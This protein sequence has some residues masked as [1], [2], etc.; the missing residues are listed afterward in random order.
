MNA[1]ILIDDRKIRAKAFAEAEKVLKKI[2]RLEQDLASFHEKDQKLFDLWSEV[3][4]REDRQEIEQKHQEYLEL[5]RFNNWILAVAQQLGISEPEA[6]LLLR[7]EQKK[8]AKGNA[9]V[10]RRIDEERLAR[11]KF[12]AD[13][14]AKEER[15]RFER[16]Q[17][18]STRRDGP[19][20]DRQESLFD[21]DFFAPSL[22][23]ILREMSDQQIPRFFGGPRITN[24][25]L[26][27]LFETMASPQDELTFLRVWDLLPDELREKAERFFKKNRKI[28][29]FAVI[30]IL[31]K[32]TSNDG[33]KSAPDSPKPAPAVT[34]PDRD[35]VAEKL[36]LKNLYRRLV[37]LLHPDLQ[38]D[39]TGFS[40]WQ[41]HSGLKK[42]NSAGLS[43]KRK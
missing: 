11:E 12:I 17:A 18:D 36:A 7:K 2:Q 42:R 4:F 1:L 40:P 29:I 16:Q 9:E 37:R 10:R 22:F 6:F 19:N 25:F 31:R 5:G 26:E 15:L 24:Q 41:R 33:A 38:E 43:N 39:K 35:P 34:P 20:F 21:D 28:S 8:Y 13:E 23:E 32:R 14:I 27:N 30:E 3:A